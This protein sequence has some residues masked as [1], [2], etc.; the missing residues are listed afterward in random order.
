[1][2]EAL[3][4]G[5]KDA[6]VR[7]YNRLLKQGKT[8]SQ[9]NSA[10]KSWMKSSDP[11][12]QQAATAIDSGDIDTYNMLINQMT[13]A[14]YGMANVVTAIEAVRK[15]GAESAEGGAQAAQ[16]EYAPVSYDQIIEA[17]ENADASAYTYA[18]MNQLLDSGN[19]RAA[20]QVQKALFKSKG[21]TAVKSAL[22]SYWKPKYQEAYQNRN[23]TELNRITRLL[24]TMGYSD[25]SINKWKNVES[26]TTNT[27]SKKTGFGSGT[28]GSSF[29]KK[30]SSKKS[31][32]SSSRFGKRF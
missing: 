1:M 2:G 22:T 31:S 23:R 12:I 19:T 7:L 17:Q 4:R 18:Q 24:K 25:Q 8:A 15:A 3:Q 32:K 11:R 27:S 14:G 9:I 21:T 30:S 29:G 20:L 10:M 13:D 5:D 28:F 6:Y 16:D 26:T